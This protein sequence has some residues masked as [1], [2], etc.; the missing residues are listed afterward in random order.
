[1]IKR[2]QKLVANAFG[3][4]GKEINGFLILLP[5]VVIFVFSEPLTRLISQGGD[6]DFSAEQQILDSLSA[7]W[8][9]NLQD[10]LLQEFQPV[11]V[12]K[13]FNFDPNTASVEELKSLGF[14]KH[15][16]MRIANY[17]QKNGKFR[18]KR[19]LLK[20]YGM[21]STLYHQ[22]FAYIQLPEEIEKVNSERLAE[23][24][25][26]DR[27]PQ[28]FDIN[29]ADTIQLKKIN[30]IGDKLA[31]RIVNF[32]ESLGGFV[33]IQQLKEVYGLDS[34]VVE[35]LAKA[36]YIENAFEPK[37]LNLNTADEKTLTAHPYIPK[38]WAKAIQ[39]Y[40]FQHGEFKD[41]RD[42]LSIEIIPPHQ[43]KRIIPY[44]KLKD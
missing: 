12:H 11:K 30:G 36:C 23:R 43:A 6:E 42:L 29:K 24:K 32:R 35:R 21:D 8:N 28:V 17:R 3:F 9:E 1:L 37:K 31:L 33:E 19:D 18:V 41:V 26:A 20:I 2:L 22:L 27:I 44:L 5:L 4:S 10:T 13:R 16:S 25:V 40:R 14:E 15:L 34:T 39:A 7:R 38:N